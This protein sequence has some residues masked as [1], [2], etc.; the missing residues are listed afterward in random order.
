VFLFDLKAQEPS[1]DT[2]K[3]KEI[4]QRQ[5]LSQLNALS[6][7]FDSL[8]YLWVGTENGL[9]RFNGDQM[10]VFKTGTQPGSLPDDHIRDMYHSNDTLWLATN[11][12]AICAYLLKEDR[13]ISFKDKLDYETI[14]SL[15][16]AYNIT[17][18]NKRYLLAGT[19]NN[20]V[21]IDRKTLTFKKFPITVE[22]ENEYITAIVPL[23]ESSYL[24]STNYKG[25]YIFDFKEQS[26]KPLHVAGDKSV[27]TILKKDSE[28]ILLGT[29]TGLFLYNTT[30]KQLKPI[31]TPIQNGEIS[32]LFIWDENQVLVT[33]AN[34]NYLINDAF[35]CK[36]IRFLDEKGKSIGTTIRSV[37]KDIQGGIWLGTEGRGVLYHHPFQEK[38][39]PHRITV[40]NAPKKDF[41]SIF[42]FLKEGDTLWM[43]TEFGLVRYLM[44]K[45]SY[46][47]Y[48]SNNLD[49]TLAKDQSGTLWAGGFGDGLLK[50]N[51]KNDTFDQ[52]PLPI[53]DNEVIQITPVSKDSIWVHTWSDGIYALNVNDYKVKRKTINGKSLLRSRNSFIDSSGDIWLASDNGLYQIHNNKT[54]YY[55]S[56]SNERVFSITEDLKKNIWAGTAKG[57]NKINVTTG[58]VEHFTQ[59]EGLPNDF[60]YG[61]ESD[62]N[63]NIWVSTNFGLSQFNPATETFTNYTEQDGLQNNEFNGKA[64][65]KDSSGRL[66]FGGMNGFNIINVDS[67]PMNKIPGNTILEDIQLFGKS[68]NKN[69]PYQNE[70]I[71]SHEQ[72]VIT[73]NFTNLSYLWPNKNLFRFKLEGF[74]KQWRPVT[75]EN[76]S[77]YTNLNPGIYTFKVRGSN[78]EMVWGNTESFK[79]VIN[80][81]WYQRLWF[82]LLVTFLVS[83]AVIGFMVH[84]HWQQKR[85]NNKLSKMVKDR[86]HSLSESNLVLQSTLEITKKQK[87]NISYLMRELNH[88]VKNNLQLM[89][90]LIDFQNVTSKS[91]EHRQQLKQLQSRIF[92]IAK[93]HDSLNQ[94][95]FNTEEIRLDKFIIQ[96]AL[97]ILS[98]T[99]SYIK[100]ETHLSPLK[101]PSNQL[102]YAGL[103]LNELITNSIKHA[104]EK[105]HPNPIISISLQIIDQEVIIEYRDNGKGFSGIELQTADT[106]G[107]S[108]IQ[109]LT[110]ELE[111]EL[112]INGKNGSCFRFMKKVVN[113]DTQLNSN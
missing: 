53:T 31:K 87:E 74:D 13:F 27:N 61:V 75:N 29:E 23:K 4:S 73:F 41:I 50:Y 66:Y 58:E 90:S 95:D 91:P 51:R 104:F 38:F 105:D 16:F 3:V 36:E 110:E 106:M 64:A 54:T 69:I 43:A 49:Y 34:R 28:H 76:S 80:T 84:R 93:I 47:L 79:I 108:L 21:L 25:C 70:L 37:K 71:L 109:L 9:N 7:E 92:T 112:E 59:Q 96:L 98:F 15:K 11:T 62:H 60:I 88:R 44:N 8:G 101:V 35:E 113:P 97:D 46:K 85:I 111:M 77:T 32:G 86:T 99:G 94:Q 102:T 100:L 81:P 72:N 20:L 22:M 2:I 30:L 78:N 55:G 18:I 89:T 17:P 14:P 52:I 68:I 12:H 5:G 56:L 67:I 82:K 45:K 57:L 65:Y 19:I 33:A 103:I 39:I 26:L 42:N 40:D 83:M 63:G 48:L 24:L 107:L 10:K 1:L 6:L